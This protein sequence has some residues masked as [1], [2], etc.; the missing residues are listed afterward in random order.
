MVTVA[1]PRIVAVTAGADALPDGATDALYIGGAGNI[2]L[3]L[4]GGNSIQLAV[5]AGAILPFKATHVTAATATGI[6]ALYY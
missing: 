2:T 3:T 5:I 6:R 1:Y 4:Q